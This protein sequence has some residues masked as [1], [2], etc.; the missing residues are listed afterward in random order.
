MS[1]KRPAI[2]PVEVW[3]QSPEPV[4]AVICGLVT[5]YEQ[6]IAKLET[7]V[8]DLTAR[9]NQNSQNSSKPPSSDG[10]HVKCKPPEAIVRAEAWWAIGPSPSS[11][12]V[13]TN[14]GSRCRYCM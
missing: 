13:S 5:Y 10:P 8:R 2:V 9:L 6:R 7:A 3:E 1:P 12:C 14:H 11:T 4:Q